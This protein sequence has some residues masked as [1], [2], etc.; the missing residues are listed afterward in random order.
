MTFGRKRSGRTEF[1]AKILQK[2]IR[3]SI[4]VNIIFSDQVKNAAFYAITI[5]FDYCQLLRC[6]D[7]VVGVS[8]KTQSLARGFGFVKKILPCTNL[9]F[10][11][12]FSDKVLPVE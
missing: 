4:R 2:R 6:S 5:D 3:L 12:F 8:S 7:R 11:K 10:Q 9:F 1:T